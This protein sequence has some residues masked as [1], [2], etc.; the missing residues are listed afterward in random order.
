MLQHLEFIL[1]LGDIEE[2][3]FEAILV[4][5]DSRELFSKDEEFINGLHSHGV[6]MEEHLEVGKAKVNSF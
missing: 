4:K 6:R 1:F 5:N 3:I 2:I